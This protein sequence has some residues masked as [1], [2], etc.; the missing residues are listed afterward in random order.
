M[1]TTRPVPVPFDIPAPRSWRFAMAGA[2]GGFVLAL[3][4]AFVLFLLD[5]QSQ[6]MT[7]GS[8]VLYSC[9]LTLFFSQFVGLSGML[10]GAVVGGV[11]GGVMGLLRE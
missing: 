1:T 11:A 6:G 3:G 8:C 4:I 9:V 2:L 7:P 10:A 5:G